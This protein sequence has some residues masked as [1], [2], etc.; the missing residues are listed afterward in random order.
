MTD[1][2]TKG[3][4]IVILLMMSACQAEESDLTVRQIDTE[5]VEDSPT[6][7]RTSP[8][9]LGRGP[10][11]GRD[12]MKNTPGSGQGRPNHH[13]GHVEQ[14]NQPDESEAI[15]SE[16]VTTEG[17]D[18]TQQSQRQKT[19]EKL[20]SDLN[21]IEFDTDNNPAKTLPKQSKD[22]LDQLG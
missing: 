13:G 19:E 21:K 10:G 16:I 3:L 6:P 4:A 5:A 9:V 1:L 8:P 14:E 17:D 7:Q 12:Y 15:S 22:A 20:E 18:K 11:M 2:Y